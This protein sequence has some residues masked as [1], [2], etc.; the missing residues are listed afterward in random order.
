MK[1]LQGKRAWITGASSGI[2]NATARVLSEAG[3]EVVLSARRVNKIEEL[4]RKIKGLGGSAL[5][6]PLDVTGYLASVADCRERF[7]GLRI[8]SGVETGESHLFAASAGAVVHGHLGSFAG[9]YLTDD[10]ADS[11]ARAGD[12]CDTLAQRMHTLLRS[13]DK[14]FGL[15]G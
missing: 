14:W 12:D 3:A 1:A 8:L 7:P 2:G 5:V 4:A 6:K 10:P 9:Q 11:A 13:L 15:R